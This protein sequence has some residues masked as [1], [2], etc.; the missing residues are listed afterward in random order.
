MLKAKGLE[1]EASGDGEAVLLIHGALIADSFLPLTREAALADRYRLIR[2][3]RRGHGGSDPM[4]PGCSIE[5]QAQDAL[6]LMTHLGVSRAHVIGHSGGGVIALQL[7]IEAPSLVHSLVVL[8]PATLPP[9]LVPVFSERVGPVL[10]AH[11]A[12]DPGRAIDLWM[13]MVGVG[14]DW[15]TTV[16]NTVPGGVE[17]AERDAS[18][19]FE[20][21]FPAFREWSLDRERASRIRQPVLYVFGSESG[22]LVE[23]LKRYF[24]S[25]VPHSEEV[26]V[27]GVGHAMQ[28]QDPKLVAAP[29]ADFLSCH[30]FSA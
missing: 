16:A 13:D 24:L 25:Q 11:R 4:P 30:P 29:I 10:E 23:A 1:Y 17:Q 2:Y 8:E 26:V 19:F 28:M 5:Q 7:A 6:A 3:R 14:A 12:G 18:T 21:D 22:P 20:V 15:R 27:P 9:D